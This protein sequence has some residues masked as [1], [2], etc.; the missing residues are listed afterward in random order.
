MQTQCPFVYARFT[1]DET[2]SKIKPFEIRI[3]CYGEDCPSQMWDPIKCINPAAPED[4]R[5]YLGGHCKVIVNICEGCSDLHKCKKSG[6]NKDSCR[7]KQIDQLFRT[8]EQPG[9][10]ATPEV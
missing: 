2:V 10:I 7:Q 6:E 1:C 4:Q 5:R 9:L 3:P 8:A